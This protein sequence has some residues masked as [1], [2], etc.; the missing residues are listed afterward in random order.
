MTRG[1]ELIILLRCHVVNHKY[2]QNYSIILIRAWEQ[3]FTDSLT[4]NTLAFP[5]HSYSH[6]VWG[7]NS[8]SPLNRGSRVSLVRQ[9]FDILD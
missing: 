2:L 4:K 9:V 5:V 7:G 3:P 1:R 6:G 8:W